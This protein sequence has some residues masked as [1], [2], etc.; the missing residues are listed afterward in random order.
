VFPLYLTTGTD[1]ALWFTENRGDKI[2]RITTAGSIREF[3][4]PTPNAGPITITTGPDGALWF[5]EE[6]GNKIGR[7]TTA[8]IPAQIDIS[9][10]RIEKKSAGPDWDLIHP[11][12]KQVTVGK[13]VSLSIYYHVSNAAASD[14][15]TI[16]WKVASGAVTVLQQRISHKLGLS[17]SGTFRDRF[18]F[19]PTR[20]GTYSVSAVVTINHQSATE[21][22]RVAAIRGAVPNPGPVTF[23]YDRLETLDAHGQVRTTFA[24]GEMLFLRAVYTVQ[25]L[26]AGIPVTVIRT[27]ERRI[28]AGWQPIGHP[29]TEHFAASSNGTQRWQVSFVPSPSYS[30][31]RIVVGLTRGSTTRK[32]TATISLR[33]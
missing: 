3:G 25:H 15:V 31:Q 1:K 8:G 32:R 22:T 28:G 27:Y 6:S 24:L 7:I 13:T 10:V 16:V 29:V 23:T 4:I 11:S 30:P 12:L 9:A 19:K 5:T 2:G 21:R 20:A 14:R 18:P 33:R 26:H 17:H